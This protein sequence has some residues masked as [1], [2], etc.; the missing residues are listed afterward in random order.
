VGA[1][2]YAIVFDITDM[3]N[4]VKTDSIQ[5]DARTI[6]DV[7]VSPDSVRRAHSRGRVESRERC[8]DPDLATPAH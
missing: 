4:I 8:R 1:D 7:T 3:S 5:V 2:G 6:N